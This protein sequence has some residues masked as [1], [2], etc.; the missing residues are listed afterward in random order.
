MN[1]Q[2]SKLITQNF[3][4]LGIVGSGTM[5]GGI[6]QIAAQHGFSVILYDINTEIVTRSVGRL[7][8]MLDKLAAK[9]KLSGD[10]VAATIS[11]IRA[12]ATLEELAAAD[13]IIE[14]APEDITLKRDIFSR[15][16]AA[17]PPTTILAS[18]TSSLS[19]TILGGATRRPAQV[20]GMHFF[21][22]VPLMGLVEVIVGQYTDEETVNSTV[23]L[24]QQLGKT[25]VRCN[26][27]PG[28][29]V[30]RV[31]RNFYGEALRIVGEQGATVEQIDQL[32]EQEAGFRMGPFRLM[33]LIGID[34][35]FA[36]T[37]SVFAAYFGE[38]RYRPHPIQQRMVEAGA[39]GRKAGRGFYDYSSDKEAAK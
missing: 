7:Q 4:T 15:L 10:D 27:T 8:A 20:V 18:N 38:P 30:N 37:Q 23:A 25:A 26:D 36:V 29:I 22:P 39:L 1:T 9:G 11:R 12:T 3:T 28:F 34:I 2:N 6:A 33:D 32:A 31:A 19:I 24:A 16:D 5:G 17:C 14:A 35:N 21:N 13:F